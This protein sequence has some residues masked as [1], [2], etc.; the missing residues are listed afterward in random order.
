MRRSEKNRLFY[1]IQSLA[2]MELERPSCHPPVIETD[3]QDRIHGG[4]QA[5]SGCT[6]KLPNGKDGRKAKNHLEGGFDYQVVAEAG[7][8]PARP[9]ASDFESL[10]STNSITLPLDSVT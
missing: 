9:K 8:E 6:A 7:L 10:M 3:E 1:V 4:E 2:G 5:E